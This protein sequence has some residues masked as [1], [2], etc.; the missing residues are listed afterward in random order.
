MSLT[1][2]DSRLH[3]IYEALP[4]PYRDA[5]DASWR[6]VSDVLR[7]GTPEMDALNVAGD[8]RAEAFAGAITRL[9]IESNPDDAAI[10][11]AIEAVDAP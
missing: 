2:A 4:S 6:A 3:A 5:I 9:V 1:R 7:E 8:D 11:A 10:K